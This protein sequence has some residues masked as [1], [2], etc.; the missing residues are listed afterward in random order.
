MTGMY[1]GSGHHHRRFMDSAERHRALH[2]VLGNIP[3][4]F[5]GKGQGCSPWVHPNL[6][7]V[8]DVSYCLFMSVLRVG[9]G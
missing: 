2:C 5:P 3:G 9:C 7:S 8:G 6:P 4:P 1:S